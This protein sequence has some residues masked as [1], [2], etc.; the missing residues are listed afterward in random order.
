[1]VKC[2]SFH[3]LYQPS[4]L[5]EQL[6]N[7]IIGIMYGTRRSDSDLRQRLH[8]GIEEIKLPHILHREVELLPLDD[9]S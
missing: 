1:M 6:Q 3:R 5:F 9:P 2:A 4:V 8:R 7:A